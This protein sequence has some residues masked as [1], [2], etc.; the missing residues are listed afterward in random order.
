Q[1]TADARDLAELLG[2]RVLSVPIEPVVDAYAEALGP[3]FAGRSADV[4]EENLQAR[5]RGNVLMALSNKFGW[6]V[7]TTGNKSE[8]SVG[9][10]TLYGDMAGGFALLQGVSKKLVYSLFQHLNSHRLARREK[11]P[12]PESTLLRPPTA[13]LRPGQRDQDVLPPYEILDE[14]LLAY[15]EK[16]MGAD[17]LVAHGFDPALVSQ[18]VR[19]VDGNEYKRRQAPP[20]IRIS[21]RAFGRDRRLPITN[22]FR[23]GEKPKRKSPKDLP[24]QSQTLRNPPAK[25]SGAPSE[26]A[27]PIRQ[28]ERSRLQ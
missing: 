5:A 12:I 9:Y 17:E 18:V 25:P 26:S 16:D 23:P 21:P 7:L 24:N 22:Q 2:I 3:A 4:T 27:G 1:S 13:E 8:L 14:I 6:L 15:V 28:S 11:P 10:C 19:W 20:G